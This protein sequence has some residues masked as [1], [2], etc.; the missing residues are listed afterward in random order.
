MHR[1]KTCWPARPTPAAGRQRR[2]GQ[3]PAVT[4]IEF[5]TFAAVDLR[6][7]LI[8]KAEP[9]KGPTSCCA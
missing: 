3:G 8:V 6:V 9:W 1:K 7:A 5:D 2:A 4:E